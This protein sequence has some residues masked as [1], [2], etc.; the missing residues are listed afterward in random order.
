MP[1]VVDIVII[2]LVLVA[3]FFALRKAFKSKGCVGCSGSD[4][5]GGSCCSSADKMVS[6]MED[7][8]SEKK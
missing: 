1:N 6:H 7:A 5:C 3:V 8:M 4:E 2:V